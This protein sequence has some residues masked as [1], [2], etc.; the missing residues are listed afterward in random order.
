MHQ[1]QLK[2]IARRHS[3]W[4]VALSSKKIAFLN[5]LKKFVGDIYFLRNLA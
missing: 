4:T 5:L 3:L 2:A 1:L